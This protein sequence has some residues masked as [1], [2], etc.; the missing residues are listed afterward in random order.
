ML[1]NKLNN[2]K[3][4][5]FVRICTYCKHLIREIKCQMKME[6]FWQLLISRDIPIINRKIEAYVWLRSLIPLDK[7]KSTNWCIVFKMS[8]DLIIWNLS[9]ISSDMHNFVN[10]IESSMAVLQGM[11]HDPKLSN[12]KYLSTVYQKLFSAT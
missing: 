7:L 8:W 2:N 10:D 6:P 9:E 5:T 12:I 1:N 11:T 3:L 4:K